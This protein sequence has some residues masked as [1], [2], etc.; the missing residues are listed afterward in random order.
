MTSPAKP[1]VV[2][3]PPSRGLRAALSLRPDQLI[4]VIS[5]FLL[6][7]TP[8]VSAYF[9]ATLYQSEITAIRNRL[10]IP[11]HA[12]SHSTGAIARNA[13]SALRNIQ[14]V[15]RNTS[16]DKFAG[17]ALRETLAYRENTSVAI[18]RIAVFDQNGVPF[19]T[20]TQDLSADISIAND[21][22]FRRQVDASTDEM[23]VSNL[24]ADPVS[25]KP[26]IIMSRRLVDASGNFRG[27]AAVFID[28]GYLQQI[29]N[30]LQMPRGTSITAFNQDGHV[31]VRTPPVHLGD[32]EITVDFTKRPMFHTFRDGPASGSFARFV[33]LTGVERFIAGVGSKDAPF[34]IAAGWDAQMAL[35]PWRREALGIG[36]ATLA[37]LAA[38]LA[39]LAYLRRQIRRN[40]DLLAKVSGAELRQ[41][42]LMTVLPDAVAIVND[43]LQVEFANPAAERI[44]GYGP[45]EMC[46]L[47]LAALMA[48]DAKE[49]DEQAAQQ[50]V[51]S[52]EEGVIRVFR[53]R[54]TRKDGSFVPV[55]I[56]TCRYRAQDGWKLISVM[57]DVSIRETNDLALRRSR[58]NLARAQR[59]AALG[60]FD[61]DLHTGVLECSDE[62]LH[63]WG[64]DP[65]VQHPTLPMLMERVVPQDREAFVA[66]RVAVL[67]G[68][69]MPQAEFRIVRPD[70]QERV[71]HQEYN[72]DFAP[73][74]RPTRLFGIVQDITE[75][76]HSEEALRRS[77]ENLARAQRI[78]AIGSFDRDLTTGRGEW[79]DEFL[80]IWGLTS[81]PPDDTPRYLASFVHPEDREKFLAGRDTA[82][83]NGPASPIDFR[84]RRADGSIRV[85]HREYGV[86]SDENGKIVR[87]FGTVQDITES[88][89]IEN[90]LRR[91]QEDLA[92]AQRIAG[93]GSFSRDLATGRVEWSEEFLHIWGIDA[94]A[95]HPTAETLATM[96]HPADR[97]AFLQGRDDALKNTSASALDFRITRRDGEER[98]LH[99]EY[100][101]LF[102]ETGKAIRMFGTVQDITERKRNELALRR[103]RENLAHSQRIAGIGSFERDL[104]TGK[105]EWSDELYRIHGVERNDPG[106]DV[107]Y[108]RNLVHP[109][110][111]DKFDQVR[112]LAAR[113]TPIPPADFRIVRP[114]GVERILHRECELV[115]DAD[116]RPIRLAATLQ[117]ITERRK[118]ELEIS[119]SRENMARAQSLASIGS[120]ERDLVTDVWEWSDEMY[121]IL[122][123]AVGDRPSPE[124][125][126][127]IVHP[128][129]RE[130]F[131]KARADERAGLPM[132][133][134]EY[135][136]IRRDGVERIV[137]R[138]SA[139]TFDAEKRPLR[140]FG[141]LQ[142]ITARKSAE[143]ELFQSRESMV[144]AQQIANMGSF[145]HDLQTGRI[146][147]SDQMYTIIGVDKDKVIPSPE[148]TLSFVHP[149]D[150]PSFIATRAGSSCPDSAPFE[151]RIVRPDGKQRVLR[152]EF[153]VHFAE[154]G[155]PLRVFGTM[156]DITER[157]A[158]EF[159]MVQSRENL[160]RA[161]RIANMGSFDHDLHT[162]RITWSDQMYAIIGIEKDSAPPSWETTLKYVHPDDRAAFR[163][164]C[165][166]ATSAN[167]EV[168][169]FRIIRPD[170]EER[171][172]RRE[173]D[174][175]FGEDGRPTRIFGMVHD[176]T[177]RVVAEEREREL[178]RQ[179]LHSQ[180]LEALGTLAGGIAHDLNN[181][182]VPIMALSKLTAR[183][184]DV[185]TPVRNNLDTIYEASER[186][187]DLV[188]RV[189]AFSRKEEPERQE[190][191]LAEI[192][193]E[194]LK[195][196]RAT[197]PT[198]IQL[199]AEIGDVSPIRADAS[200]IHQVITNLV[201]N[202]AGAMT[203]GMGT[204]TVSLN[205][206]AAQKRA[207]SEIC[208]SVSDTGCGM[209]EATL[210]RIFEPFFTTKAVGQGTGL[211][212]S[213]VHGI[214]TS[215][216]GRID[217]KS[218][219][220]KG[221]RF[222]LYFPLPATDGNGEKNQADKPSEAKTSRP[223]A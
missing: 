181:T 37:G 187:R 140:I 194:A 69:G 88:K 80:K 78:A 146:T 12:I 116:G 135:R 103:S 18:D 163:A 217:V 169:E 102:S 201:S 179:L 156:Q 192:V 159:E 19:L 9:I 121:R 191:N 75:R 105:W 134:L 196:M 92:R 62:F 58:E 30:S 41:R 3:P 113:G 136:M 193:R 133:P 81:R 11:A 93:L 107:V 87:L 104:V 14:S 173:I 117:D 48:D 25:G 76:T 34:I 108:L 170:G 20:S 89:A 123:V 83:R 207:P 147:W 137:R 33:A 4:L 38:S 70:G 95:E 99:R 148:L 168:F 149:D 2:R 61:R 210:Q 17:A 172:L 43:L 71:L 120:F 79:S 129:D 202:A 183:R 101:V 35:A 164:A 24:V 122:G 132:P 167:S 31:V 143:I 131:L 219:P 74:G 118:A 209:D 90:E 111:R 127:E 94:H 165:N 221:T 67:S 23:L 157:R 142:D 182:L 47:P 106:V 98:I 160:M 115:Y 82:L 72:A 22:F 86:L 60:S 28:V 55:E 59:L 36:G 10:E 21:E 190:A 85:L 223:A 50:A 15:L 138:E 109:E 184:F 180:K 141:T 203:N 84:I 199:D 158:A 174:G 214:V 119:R 204:I 145:D 177:Q 7:A 206:A 110:D 57:R 65:E 1:V 42:Q 185:G 166:C 66:S 32:E 5:A 218:V 178:E 154:D 175:H 97:A 45:G 200:Q 39:L 46:G 16:K 64:F 189:L 56:S 188:R 26:E 222:D 162:D 161:Q 96:V 40:D 195:L 220:G 29:F 51:S 171:V 91:S 152:R 215:H 126:I 205:L 6:I 100:G 73:D 114:D 68:K 52:G 197:V 176:I 150:R 186:A 130:R 77:R 8:L 27:V 213:I 54:N 151:F 112:D 212:L 198:S 144:R 216:G 208:L 124:E 63:I 128:D 13:D 153:D 125:L 53:R 139:V 155:R 44:H 49:A 211:G